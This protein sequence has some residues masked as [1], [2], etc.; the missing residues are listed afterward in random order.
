VIGH[1]DFAAWCPP[2]PNPQPA[3]LSRPMSMVHGQCEQVVCE[4]LLP[5]PTAGTAASLV[6]EAG[7]GK[8]VNSANNVRL[9]HYITNRRTAEPHQRRKTT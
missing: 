8:G 2:I 6:P 9:P 4:S 7:R 3:I 5:I 1:D